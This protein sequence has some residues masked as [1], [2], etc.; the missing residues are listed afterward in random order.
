MLSILAV[1]PFFAFFT[2]K[3]LG[4]NADTLFGA[5]CFLLLG[6]FILTKFITKGKIKIPMYTMLFGCFFLYAFLMDVLVSGNF[7]KGSP[8]NYFY[9]SDYLRFFIACILIENTKFPKK[10]IDIAITAM[11]VVLGLAACVSIL[12]IDNPLFFAKK[13][14]GLSGDL[15]A[16]RLQYYFS[17]S[18]EKKSLEI[19]HMLSGYRHSIYSWIHDLSVGIDSIA[20]LSILLGLKHLSKLKRLVIYGSGALVSFLVSSRWVLLN[21]FVVASQSFWFKKNKIIYALKY[22]LYGVGLLVMMAYAA[23]FMGIDVEKFVEDRLMSDSA[24]TRLYAFEVFGKVFP[25]NPILGTGGEDTPEMLRLIK[26][27]T[28]Q[29]HVGYLKLF[30]YYGIIGGL[31]YLTF[32]GSFLLNLWRRA[33]RTGFWGSFFAILAFAVANLTLYE[34]DL[35]FHGPMLAILFAGAINYNEKKQDQVP[36]PKSMEL[37]QAHQ[38]V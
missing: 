6:E 13:S 2:E 16:E 28:S 36:V 29:I 37:A 18:T 5:L 12:Q 38:P 10:F 33:K 23:S 17:E 7:F 30:Y 14:F 15:S 25:D 19:R 1:Y 9:T 31:L 34:T 24:L 26:G 27:R 35:F 32:L 8:V 21:F 22:S 20:V 3:Y 11:I 4:K